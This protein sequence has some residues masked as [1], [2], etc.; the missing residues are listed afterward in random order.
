M[1][2]VLAGVVFI[3]LVGY[4]VNLALLG[5]QR[6]WIGWAATGGAV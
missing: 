4:L 5:A 6:R 2:M 1:D 3:G